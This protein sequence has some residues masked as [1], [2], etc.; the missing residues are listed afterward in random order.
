MQ[1]SFH[2][3]TYEFQLQAFCMCE[4][5]GIQFALQLVGVVKQKEVAYFISLSK[6]VIW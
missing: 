1:S 3:I 6:T 4:T 5:K 2:C